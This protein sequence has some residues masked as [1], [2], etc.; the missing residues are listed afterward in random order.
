MRG[1][2]GRG[3]F[4]GG[5]EGGWEGEDVGVDGREGGV[6]GFGGR[7]GHGGMGGCVGGEGWW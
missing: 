6:G 3:R 7:G 1:E 2:G 5:G 4:C